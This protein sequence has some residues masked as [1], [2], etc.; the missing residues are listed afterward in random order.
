[1]TYCPPHGTP[2]E[3]VFTA[4]MGAELL[5]Q[6]DT[7]LGCGDSFT[8]PGSASV[9]ITVTDDDGALSGDAYRNERGDD[10]SWQTADIEV[11]GA[12][13]HADTKVY[14]EEYYVLHGDDGR[15]YYMV[16]IETLGSAER[17]ADDFYAFIGDVP[18][19]GVIL[20]VA[21]KGNVCGNWLDYRDLT[22]GLKWDLD[23][24]GKVTIEAEDMALRGY[25]VDDVAAASG[26]EVIR[27]KKSSGEASVT[28][29][30][31]SGTYDLELAYIDENDGEGEIEIWLGDTLL[32]TI[33]LDRNDN[34]NG[35][36]GSSISTVKIEGVALV[37]GDFIT[38]RGTR[39]CWEYARIDALTFC[40]VKNA[41]PVAE[42]DA[43]ATD[44]DSPVTL[45]LLANDSDPDGDAL[46]LVSVAGQ[47]PATPFQV[48]FAGGRTGSVAVTA[49]GL[50]TFTPDD[51]FD[52]MAEGD[53]DTVT[54]SYSISDGNG[55]SAE[56]TATVTVHGVNDAP[57]AGDDFFTTGES[58]LATFDITPNDSDPEGDPLTYT[59]LSQ[60]IEGSVTLNAENRIVFDPGTDFLAL[61]DGQTATVQFEYSVSDGQF[62]DTAAVTI[63][64][65]GEGVCISETTVV[66]DYG[67]TASGERVTLTLEAPDLTKDGSAKFTI[68]AS[69]GDDTTRY[70]FVYVLDIS[71]STG[72]AD[73]FA[74]GQTVLEA[75]IEALSIL[76][77]DILS[78][79]LPE[80]SVKISII[81]FNDPA[82]LEAPVPGTGFPVITFD[83][84]D[85]N[86]VLS[87]VTDA[88]GAL[89]ANGETNYLAA[90]GA[91]SQTVLLDEA[92]NGD[93]ENIV[94]FL[95]DGNPFPQ[96]QP[97]PVIGG[98]A[99]YLKSQATVHAVGLL[100]Q[101][102]DPAVRIEDT[103]FLDPID[104]SGGAVLVDDLASLSDALDVAPV[105]PFILLAE[106][107]LTGTDG[108]V[109]DTFQFTASDFDETPVGFE[110]D[111]SGTAAITG[112]ERFAGD[113]NTA[114]LT[115]QLD[116]NG[117][118]IADDTV[119][120]AA[121]IEGMLPLSFDFA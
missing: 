105:D 98:F 111:L 50:L 81:P 58:G 71:G 103:T 99:T 70:H 75:E 118:G 104:N 61:E 30:A 29:G 53:T 97:A 63:Q 116:D 21:G 68:R 77:A 49:A 101:G 13:L 24:E 60:P 17:D 3:Y 62:T 112:L 120:L 109:L 91:T 76:T 66:S 26:G 119:A 106:L 73:G 45:D 100:N 93:A 9:C 78:L 52:A 82:D 67:T 36:D 54:V 11:D 72:V 107:V 44:E 10:Q 113:L 94:Y 35:G 16:E 20:S 42:H 27:L 51:S 4:L 6:G 1:M 65:H 48:T 7:E 121:E 8:M 43:V 59:L 41:P 14:A 92:L 47:E 88:L 31:D 95:S 38:L 89:E 2:Q 86:P 85:A 15:C 108:T 23:A 22:A 33:A 32:H 12:L 55:E 79:G 46:T 28:F 25:K 40:A 117:D 74:P 34:G 96:V 115:L 18:A 56:A 19:A 102:I 110:L 57:V 84:A 83:A 37:E 80:G 5:V 114:T 69:L 90:V 39:D 64:V 87:D